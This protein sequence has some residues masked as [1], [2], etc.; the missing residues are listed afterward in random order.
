MLHVLCYASMTAPKKFAG[1]PLPLT[2]RYALNQLIHPLLHAPVMGT[3]PIRSSTLRALL[4]LFKTGAGA[5]RECAL[6][7]LLGD[8]GEGSVA[9]HAPCEWTNQARQI[10]AGDDLGNLAPAVS[11]PHQVPM[12]DRAT[13]QQ[14]S[15]S[16]KQNPLLRERGANQF[17][18]A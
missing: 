3:L 13:F 12:S 4:K 5:R 1:N 7:L 2:P 16:R 8:L 11:L 14:S 17:A 9:N 15:I 6:D 18:V 10:E